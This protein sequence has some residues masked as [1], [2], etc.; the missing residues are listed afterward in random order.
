MVLERPLGIN[1]AIERP[2]CGDFAAAVGPFVT[3]SRSS[4]L[5]PN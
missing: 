1:G 2:L 3:V 5:D 4:L